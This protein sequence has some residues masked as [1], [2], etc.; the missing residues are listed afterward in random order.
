MRHP[1]YPD[2]I[3][4]I[5]ERDF[6][7]GLRI[8]AAGTRPD[9]LLQA[10]R[11]GRRGK[12]REA[13][14]KLAQYH[15]YSLQ[16][17]WEYLRKHGTPDPIHA[18]R[19]VADD[20]VK[21]CFYYSAAACRQYGKSISWDEPET[22]SILDCF[23]W[24]IPLI[25]AYMEK[26][27]ESYR[28]ALCDI[29]NQ[30][31]AARNHRRFPSPGYHPVYSALNG[32]VKL[33]NIFPA[34]IALAVRGGL[35]PQSAESFLK[36]CMGIAR[37]LHRRETD[38]F[39]SNQTIT[40]A[41][42]SGIFACAFPE[43]RESPAMRGQAIER[44]LQNVEE[45][46]L[47]DGGYYERSFE[48]SCVAIRD[49]SRAVMMFERSAPLESALRK[50]FAKV[51]QM[52]GRFMI[53]T[54]GPDGWYPPYA[55]GAI[56]RSDEVLQR[57]LPFFPKGT[58]PD[59][60]EVPGRS[61]FFKDSGFAVLRSGSSR[62]DAYAFFSF[63][64][65]D[66]WHCHQDCLTFDFWRYGRPLLLEAGRFGL[67]EE[68]QSR[69]FRMPEM[70]NT[71]TIDGQFWDE[72]HPELWR[73]EEVRWLSTPEIDYV[74][75]AHRA[76]RGDMPVLP[77]AQNYRL[78]RAIVFVKDPGYALVFDTVDN[79]TSFPVGVIAQHWHS[80]SPFHVLGP[81]C[82]R[83]G[84]KVGVLIQTLVTGDLRRTEIGDD[85]RPDEVKV[86]NA[87]PERHRLS[88]RRWA[89]SSTGGPL[90]FVTV[91][92]PYEGKPAAVEIR[93]EPLDGRAGWQAGCITVETPAGRDLFVLNPDCLEGVSY[94]GRR[95]KGA[96][97]VILR[98]TAPVQ[99]P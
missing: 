89:D 71:L 26:P 82:A 28:R 36:L 27:G 85:Y 86:N 60:G 64:R 33:H 90:G 57:V 22:G 61:F 37:A 2:R 1:D 63:G 17:E 70:H 40:N 34:Y 99:L 3:C 30:Y 15:A 19:Q 5:S 88:F 51:Y 46:F 53:R 77:Q 8:D 47:P 32:S 97:K 35:D 91:I 41:E 18:P 87:F 84:G 11:L 6:W 69:L 56:R 92:H 13:Y 31:Y 48:Y 39:L 96:G 38:F 10:V 43:F 59:L 49:S 83:A 81:G 14:L 80:P 25:R 42:S 78:R 68:P 24:Y 66:L 95:I 44:I 16:G 20:V 4:D 23:Y 93:N 62:E 65:C 52:A 50:R 74:S 45:G 98:G 73:G 75:A 76:Y 29:I 79:E 55:D 9:L 67:Y 94:R 54:A 7:G 12:K 58:P 21:H 72:R